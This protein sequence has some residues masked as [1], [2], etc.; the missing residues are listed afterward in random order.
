MAEVANR[1]KDCIICGGLTG[2]REHVFPSALGG[3]REDKKIYCSNHNQWMG[4]HVGVLQKQLEAINAML[5]VQPDRGAVKAHVFEADNGERYA[6]K[7]GDISPAPDLDAILDGYTLGEPH[8]LKIAPGD[9]PRLKER[10]KQRGLKLNIVEKASPVAECRVGHY[11]IPMMQGGD[12][13]M[14]AVGYLALTFVAHLWP[15]VGRAPGLAAIKEMLRSGPIYAGPD[16]IAS[17]IPASGFVAW[18]PVLG[19][20]SE[21]V[22]PTGLGHTIVLCLRAGQVLAYLSLLDLQCWTIRL[23][24]AA[25]D[26]ADRTVVV[27]VDPLKTRYGDDWTIHEF[28]QTSLADEQAA[29]ESDRVSLRA[30]REALDTEATTLRAQAEAAGQAE[31]LAVAHATELQRLVTHLEA[32]VEELSRQRD[33]AATR[34]AEREV[35]RQSLEARLQVLQASAEAE[36]DE[37]LQ[38]IRA[39]EDR[40]NTEIDRARQESKELQVR[41]GTVIKDHASVEKMLRQEADQARASA[42]EGIRDASI[43]RAR[44]DALEK[45][46]SILQDLPAVLEAAMRQTRSRQKQPKSGSAVAARAA[47]KRP[48]GSSGAG[49]ALDAAEN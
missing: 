24:Q 41:L 15:H 26:T 40:A 23:G 4:P 25:P 49:N 5:E 13:A 48:K 43:E 12:D 39:V 46:L 47:G 42:V 33:A 20:P 19:A 28:D 2:S 36:R 22:H 34:E 7:G 9:L 10:A 35:A 38:H 45:Q 6:I 8:Q 29:V 14:R 16:A 11:R 37:L 1:P 44:A 17:P 27:H 18:S 21:L 3:R 32:Q 31:H 30:A